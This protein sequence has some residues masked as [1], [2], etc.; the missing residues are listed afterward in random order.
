MN[1]RRCPGHGCPCPNHLPPPKYR[2]LS[3]EVVPPDPDQRIAGYVFRC[4]TEDRVRTVWFEELRD[5]RYVKT[6]L[7]ESPPASWVPAFER[8]DRFMTRTA[9]S[10]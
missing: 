7:P 1:R 3:A 8:A 4:E 2:F 6:P 9:V 5:G 10:A